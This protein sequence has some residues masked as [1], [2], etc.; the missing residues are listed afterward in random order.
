[1]IDWALEKYH[2]DFLSDPEELAIPIR[3]MDRGTLIKCY[4]F[5]LLDRFDTILWAETRK[6]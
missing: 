5:P 3:T 4:D 6:R 2:A 1:M